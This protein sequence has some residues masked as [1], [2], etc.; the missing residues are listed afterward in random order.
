[1]L[2]KI[3]PAGGLWSQT[4]E[5]NEANKNWLFLRGWTKTMIRR[6]LGA[7]DRISVLRLRRSQIRR[8]D[9]PECLYSMRRVLDAEYTPEFLAWKARLDRIRERAESRS[10][11]LRI[12]SKPRY[13]R[14]LCGWETEIP[15]YARAAY[16][17]LSD[18]DKRIIVLLFRRG[19]RQRE[20]A[21]EIQVSQQTVSLVKTL[22]V[23]QCKVPSIEDY[24]YADYNN[25][26]D[27]VGKS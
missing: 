3:E 9:R 21:G 19:K 26:E 7:P 14:P 17:A 6:F 11:D 15:D 10:D 8:K 20:V 16:E 22:F 23:A 1:M 27:R 12:E 2:G 18:R 24:K 4:Q 13:G 25:A 5:Q